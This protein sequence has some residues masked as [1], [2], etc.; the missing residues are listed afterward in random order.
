MAG[1]FAGDFG[2]PSAPVPAH[3]PRRG[4]LLS[5]RDLIAL[6]PSPVFFS[7][8]SIFCFLLHFPGTSGEDLHSFNSIRFVF[9]NFVGNFSGLLDWR[10]V[11]PPVSPYTSHR[12]GPLRFN[13]SLRRLATFFCL[14]SVGW[15]KNA[16]CRHLVI[17]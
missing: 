5:E 4:V 10:A 17:S 2:S 12:E 3:L 14:E 16:G 6:E 15:G 7:L 13:C 8:K 1:L 9:L 11:N